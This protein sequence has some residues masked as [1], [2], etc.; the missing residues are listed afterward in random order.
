MPVIPEI[1]RLRQADLELEDSMHYIT[2]ISLYPLSREIYIAQNI[3][4]GILS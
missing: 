3:T 2:T 1:R 4:E